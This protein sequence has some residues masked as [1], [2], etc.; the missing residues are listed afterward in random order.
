M[1]H[2]TSRP[3]QGDLACPWADWQRPRPV[4]SLPRLLGCQWLE[5]EGSLGSDQSKDPGW[6][7]QIGFI[8]RGVTSLCCHTKIWV[9]G[10]F[11]S[12]PLL[13]PLPPSQHRGVLQPLEGSGTLSAVMAVAPAAAAAFG[14]CTSS[15]VPALWCNGNQTPAP[16]S[17][18]PAHP[19]CPAVSQA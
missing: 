9:S 8:R 19:G 12:C 13:P 3:A 17:I 10:L 6:A 7:F 1:Y 16:C 4:T 18:P 14:G 15:T 11:V 5:P 2:S